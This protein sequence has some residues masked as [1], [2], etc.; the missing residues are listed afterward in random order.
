MNVYSA[1][2]GPLIRDGRLNLSPAS[3]ERLGVPAS[4]E[5][6]RYEIAQGALNPERYSEILKQ[7]N[8]TNLHASLSMMDR[9]QVVARRHP[10]VIVPS[11]LD[12]DFH[13]IL[14]DLRARIR[15]EAASRGVVLIPSTNAQVL[16]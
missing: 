11:D 16:Q 14:D 7:V 8:N 1:D 9:A 15:A 2:G 13:D 12:A 6:W 3:A 5:S 10:G 4:L